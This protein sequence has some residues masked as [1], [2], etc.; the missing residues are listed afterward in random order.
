MILGI[1]QIYMQSRCGYYL[2]SQFLY[3]KIEYYSIITYISILCTFY[4]VLRDIETVITF[5]CTFI[6]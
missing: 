1:K 5:T 3:V 6:I 2:S 4:I